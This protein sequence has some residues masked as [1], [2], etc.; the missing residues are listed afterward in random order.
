MLLQMRNILK[1]QN[2]VAKCKV[3]KQDQVL[4]DLAHVADVGY[5]WEAEFAG[6]QT[7]GD[8]FRN[9]CQA[10]AIRLNDMYCS[11]LHEIVE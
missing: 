9:P 2:L 4:M 11:G 3:V 8:K 6:E 1:K 5:H 10:S 7:D